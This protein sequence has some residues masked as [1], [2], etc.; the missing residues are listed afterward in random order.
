MIALLINP[1]ER[2]KLNT[3]RSF[4][5]DLIKSFLIIC[6]LFGHSLSMINKTI[7]I[8]WVESPINV[9][10]TI[11]EMPLFILLSG[12]FLNSSIQK[13][14]YNKVLIKRIIA[15]GIPF[16]F[17][18]I[19]LQ[20]IL[21]FINV[22]Q[23]KEA[24]S[25]SAIIHV[26]IGSKYWFIRALLLSS[27]VVLAIDWIMSHIK[28]EVISLV[29]ELFAILIMWSFFACFLNYYYL[30]CMFIF[31][32]L[33]FFINKMR[34]TLNKITFIIL[35]LFSVAFIPLLLFYKPE[36]SFYILNPNFIR[37]VNVIPILLLRFAIEISGCSFIF[38]F[39]FFFQ[40]IL[41]A[42]FIKRVISY[43]GSITLPIYLIS[44]LLQ[45][46]LRLLIIKTIVPSLLNNYFIIVCFGCCF[47]FV[48]FGLCILIVWLIEKIPLF[49]FCLFG[50]KPLIQKQHADTIRN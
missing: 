13:H 31:F 33:G 25:L 44:M 4:F 27:L 48:L 1:Q 42:A 40:K 9:F 16:L 37:N 43:I 14:G 22:A 2:N 34:I 35:I 32:S 24:L 8:S 19:F 11:F 47:F 5:A 28:K 3:N 15:L 41:V 26:I 10:L 50:S 38:V 49:Y 12:F 23:G 6:V 30:E 46:L 39:L 21:L 18:D 7:G 36:I 45:E 17:W 29:L 20:Y